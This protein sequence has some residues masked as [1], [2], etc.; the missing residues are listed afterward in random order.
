MEY[1]IYN[2]SLVKYALK[3]PISGTYLH[4]AALQG[5]LGVGIDAAD[6]KETIKEITEFRDFVSKDNSKLKDLQIRKVKVIDI[7]EVNE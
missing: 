5:P 2:E 1:T 6:K 3:D 7:G 4:Y